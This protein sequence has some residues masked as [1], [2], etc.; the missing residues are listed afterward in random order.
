LIGSRS[1]YTE[2]ATDLEI[3]VDRCLF[4]LHKVVDAN[5]VLLNLYPTLL[6]PVSA[7]S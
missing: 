5:Y 3:L 6:L 2:V 1:V 4:R 7:T